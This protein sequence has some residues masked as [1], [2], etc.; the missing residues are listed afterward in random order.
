M[1]LDEICAYKREEVR[2]RKSMA[3]VARLQESL[4]QFGPARDFRAALRREGISLIAEIKRRSPVK[5]PLM[6]DA[7]AVDIAGLY[8]QAG[9]RAISIL[10]DAK[11]FQGAFEDLTEV[12]R[13]VK[14]PCLQK[15]FIVDEYQI[16]E[17]R[18]VGADAILLIVRIL[19]DPQLKD[20]L[21]LSSDLGMA[22]VVETHDAAEIER[23]LF[24][25]AHIVGINNR[26]LT[27]FKVD[28]NTTLE[29]KKMV[30]GGNVLVS[31]S[32][33]HTREHVRRLEDGGVD[34]ILVGEALMTSQNIVE[35]I[36]ELFGVHES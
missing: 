23:A 29:L 9:A 7:V 30:P 36:Q 16:H 5:G 11:Y 15:E 18:A 21:E 13:A 28:I 17:A 4:D 3:P 2:A 34:A 22:T 10:T 20:Y 31:E 14:L 35:K 27:T 19:S 26:D 12:R 6:E 25:G 33:I 8:E 32:G 1:I 24:A